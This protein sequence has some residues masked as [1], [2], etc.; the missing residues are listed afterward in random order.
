MLGPLRVQP[1]A[2]SK[3]YDF[4]GPLRPAAYGPK[5]TVP[6]SIPWPDYA[7]GSVPI[8][9]RIDKASNTAIKVREPRPSC[10]RSRLTL[11]LR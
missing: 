6:A 11:G 9:E 2:W 8:S 7:V 4:S 3:S 10:A 1:P 5:R